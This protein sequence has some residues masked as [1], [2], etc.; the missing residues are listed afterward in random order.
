[1]VSAADGGLHDFVQLEHPYIERGGSAD[2][3]DAERLALLMAKAG[4][5]E[6][7]GRAQAMAV[8]LVTLRR[9]RIFELA[10]RLYVRGSLTGAEVRASF[11]C[12]ESY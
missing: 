12:A 8:Q 7:M 3:A 6:I 2:H 4:A 11:A 9:E 5:V 1:V 10:R